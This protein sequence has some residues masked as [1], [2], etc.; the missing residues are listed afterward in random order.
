MFPKG[1]W[2]VH[3]D[4]FLEL[5]DR[6]PSLYLTFDTRHAHMADSTDRMALEF[7]EKL[8]Q[9]IGHVHTSDNFGVE[10]SHLPVGAGSV[11]FKPWS[12]R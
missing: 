7:I 2:L 9:R 10:D 6:F 1:H 12:G 4:D 5:L 8:S 3:P 11:D